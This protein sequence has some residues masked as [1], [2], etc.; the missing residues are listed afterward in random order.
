MMMV[1][2]QD[3][4]SLRRRGMGLILGRMEVSIMANGLIIKL[5]ALVNMN[6]QTVGNTKETGKIMLW[7]V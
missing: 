6:G 3:N 4:I 5:M 1:S 2:I 7:K